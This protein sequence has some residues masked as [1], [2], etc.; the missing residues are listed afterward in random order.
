MIDV[1]SVAR[2]FPCIM[3][4]WYSFKPLDLFAL[5]LSLHLL[6]LRKESERERERDRPANCRNLFCSALGMCFECLRLSRAS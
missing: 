2:S 6:H 1:M 5:A 3:G 4:R